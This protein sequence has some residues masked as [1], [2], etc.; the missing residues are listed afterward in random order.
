MIGTYGETI[1]AEE[2]LAV[3]AKALAL[4]PNLG[5]AHAAHGEALAVI[6]RGDEAKIAFER[7]LQLDP[8]S[9]EVN[10]S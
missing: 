1:S 4:D 9:F 6:N 5:E 10:Y 8:N 7:A 2:I 3:T